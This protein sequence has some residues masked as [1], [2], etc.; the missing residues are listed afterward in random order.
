MESA[1]QDRRRCFAH[2]RVG[3]Q[4]A[5]YIPL[6][7]YCLLMI[8]RRSLFFLTQSTPWVS[9]PV[10]LPSELSATKNSHT[11][12]VKDLLDTAI[13]FTPNAPLLDRA[14]FQARANHDC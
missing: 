10:T 14:G 5:P 2:Q 9:F 8:V 3:A 13:E 1:L 4:S 7:K 6:P 12:F 11:A